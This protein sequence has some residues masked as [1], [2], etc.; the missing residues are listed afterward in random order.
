MQEL[1]EGDMALTVAKSLPA[2]LHLYNTI[3]GEMLACKLLLRGKQKFNKLHSGCDSLY[4]WQCVVTQG[5]H[6]NKLRPVCVERQRGEERQHMRPPARTF[7]IS[8]L[9]FWAAKLPFKVFPEHSW[10]HKRVNLMNAAWLWVGAQN[11]DGLKH[12]PCPQT[13]AR[14]LAPTFV[15]SK[16]MTL[17]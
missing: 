11:R 17:K 7:F 8:N 4:R 12:N 16:K 6:S 9:V 2:G 3:T 13:I 10:L 14:P 1:W 5:R 15:W